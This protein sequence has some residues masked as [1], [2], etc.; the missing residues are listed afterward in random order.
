MAA[1]SAGA[2][3]EKTCLMTVREMDPADTG[4]VVGLW[5]RCGLLRPWN[6]P[7]RDIE[8]SRCSPASTIF[9]VEQ[10]ASIVGSIMVGFDGHRGWIYYLA[11]EPE[12]QRQGFGRRL[13]AAAEEWLRAQGAP[14]IQLMVREGNADAV[15]FYERLGLESQAVVTLGRRLD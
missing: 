1:G 11:V 2:L 12:L 14:K 7:V 8:L 5:H 9:V 13:M 6:D 4:E 15:R 10:G 3:G